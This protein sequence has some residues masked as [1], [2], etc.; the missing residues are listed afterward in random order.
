MYEAEG[1][2][3]KYC[4]WGSVG[5]RQRPVRN[6]EGKRLHILFSQASKCLRILNFLNDWKAFFYK[7]LTLWGQNTMTGGLQI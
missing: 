1:N 5:R 6:P 4:S 7:G 3:L 2:V